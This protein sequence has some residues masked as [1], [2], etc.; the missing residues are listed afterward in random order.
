MSKNPTIAAIQ[1]SARAVPQPAE[2]Q[3]AD[4]TDLGASQATNVLSTLEPDGRRRWLL[5]R[6]AYG[7]LW[8]WRRAT[9]YILIALF[10]M[11][12]YLKINGKPSVLLDLT[13]RRFTLFGKTFL[14]TDTLLLALLMVSIFVAIFLITAIAGRIWC[15]WGCPQTVYME[16]VYRPIERFFGGAPGRART[17]F[18]QSGLALGLKH[19][20]F[21]A[22]SCFL[23][24]TFLAYFV[25]V[26]RLAQ[27]VQSSPA[28]HPTPFLVM[29]VTTGLMM[30]DFVWFREQT[31][32][33]AC[34]YG[35]FQSVMID[36][37]SKII[38]YDRARGEPRGKPAKK[39]ARP[40]DSTVPLPVLN[41][42][43]HAVGDCVDCRMCVTTCPT[44]IDIRNGLQMECINCAQCIDACDA[45]MV[46]LG[47]PTGL[48]RYS[49]LATM[50]GQEQHVLRP[51]IVIYPVILLVLVTAFFVVLAR[52]GDTDINVL[53]GLGSP[54]VT[55]PD[56]MIGNQL[57][58]NVVNRRDVPAT[59]QLGATGAPGVKISSESFPLTLQPGEMKL[60]PALVMAPQSSFTGGACPVQVVIDDGAKQIGSWPYRMMGPAGGRRADDPR[61]DENKNDNRGTSNEHR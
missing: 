30:F 58:I 43:A 38:S 54:F 55:L 33:L 39:S 16:F 59:Y 19:V 1:P 14:P 51:R 11:L 3:D 52:K 57:R 41:G 9:A 45:V 17:A 53:R 31:C 23:A 6:P 22:V 25:G 44:G 8:R 49:S 36:R 37:Q 34:P 35:R 56:G 12:P 20:A 29:A 28:Q 4:R 60:V 46:K 50:E 21:F 7:K 5:P 32:I 10:T 40:A 26:E 47:R 61:P 18:Q 27:W 24:H 2:D 15:G 42:A 48:V 13:T